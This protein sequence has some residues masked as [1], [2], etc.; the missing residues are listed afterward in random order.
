MPQDETRRGGGRSWR[1]DTAHPVP[2]D[3]APARRECAQPLRFSRPDAAVPRWDSLSRARGIPGREMKTEM[4][5][6]A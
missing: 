2:R 5:C 1:D 3:A 4:L 6:C